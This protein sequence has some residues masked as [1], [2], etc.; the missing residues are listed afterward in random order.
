[1]AATKRAR[2]E[3]EFDKEDFQNTHGFDDETYVLGIDEAGRGSVL[4]NMIYGGAVVTLG[5]HDRLVRTGAAD[6]KALTAESREYIKDLLLTKVPTFKAFVKDVTAETICEAMSGRKGRNLNTLSHETAIKIIQEAVL[7]CKGK[8]AAVYVDTVGIPEAY[9]RML[10]GRF[11]H[12]LVTVTSKADAKFPIVSAA[13]IMA[14][15]R[16]DESVDPSVFPGGFD[17]GTGYPSDPKAVAF[18]RQHL[19]RFF[20]Y[21]ARYTSEVRHSWRPIVELVKDQCVPIEFE[22]DLDKDTL[23][24]RNNKLTFEKAPPSRDPIFTH[25][26][27]LKSTQKINFK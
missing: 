27:G 5:D 1:M 8:L 7:Y 19:H 11:P 16:R 10:R 23:S 18:T 6:S 21:P 24:A 22:Q 15:T 26:F 20:G 3:V 25:V 12:L 9:E 2:V 17:I 14:K 4:G 13:S